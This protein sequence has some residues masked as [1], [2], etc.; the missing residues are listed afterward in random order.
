M[1]GFR[2]NGRGVL[3]LG[4]QNVTGTTN[5]AGLTCTLLGDAPVSGTQ[6][7]FV[8]GVKENEGP[9]SAQSFS[10]H[11]FAIGALNNNGTIQ[12][13]AN[14]NIKRVFAMQGRVQ[15]TMS[16]SDFHNNLTAA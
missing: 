12:F 15:D 9:T 16:A 4:T 6:E 13:Y 1:I 11:T 10:G 8:N 7:L 14:G 3:T 2:S 5:L